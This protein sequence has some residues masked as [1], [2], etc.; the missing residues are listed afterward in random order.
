MYALAIILVSKYVNNWGQRN[1]CDI[2]KYIILDNMTLY[3]SDT[4]DTKALEL[5]KSNTTTVP[6]ASKPVHRN[7][8]F[9]H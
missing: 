3:C 8:G 6:L 9:L 1:L 2:V 4:Q 7:I 5:W